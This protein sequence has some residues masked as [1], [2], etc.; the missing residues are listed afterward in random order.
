MNAFSSELQR[1]FGARRRLPF[2]VRKWTARIIE[3]TRSL[4]TAFRIYVSGEARRRAV[5]ARLHKADIILASPRIATLF[6]I[7]LGYRLLL[8]SRYVHSMLY[9]GGGK[10]IHTTVR[11]GVVV[12]RV[13][14][15]IFRRERYAIFRVKDLT[16]EGRDRVVEA[17]LT[18]RKRKLDYAGLITTV[19]SR[20]VGLRRPLLRWEK[21]R[22]W[23]SKLVYKAFLD[24][25]IE[26]VPAEDAESITSEDLSKSSMVEKISK[27]NP[28]KAHT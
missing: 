22:I 3:R 18:W 15:S 10:I 2:D 24:Q 1:L 14:R 25:G 16:P 6:P 11:D 26:L 21:N 23:C 20:L 27:K 13:P 12:N 5:I 4:V 19:P 7:A 9:I 17:A 28:R 8:R